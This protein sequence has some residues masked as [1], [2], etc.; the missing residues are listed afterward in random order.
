MLAPSLPRDAFPVLPVPGFPVFG[1][2]GRRLDAVALCFDGGALRIGDATMAPGPVAK[3]FNAVALLPDV[4]TR[5]F[6]HSAL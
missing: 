2:T 4:G 3:I 5:K 1:N 6:N